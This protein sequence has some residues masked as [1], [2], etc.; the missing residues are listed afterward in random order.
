M[1][2]KER[3]VFQDSFYGILSVKRAPSM[4]TA[5]G[6]RV[7]DQYE[8]DSSVDKQMKSIYEIHEEEK[9]DKRGPQDLGLWD[10][11]FS[12]DVV[13]KLDLLQRQAPHLCLKYYCT[14]H[15]EGEISDGIRI[16]RTSKSS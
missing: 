6:R 15:Y 14:I 13:H 11:L 12:R 1:S 5:W 3:M 8:I 9:C 7:Y 16:T 4:D 2:V 10:L